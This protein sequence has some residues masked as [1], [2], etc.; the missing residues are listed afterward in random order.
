MEYSLILVL[1]V[2]IIR[3][4]GAVMLVLRKRTMKRSMIGGTPESEKPALSGLIPAGLG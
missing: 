3:A 2:D 1:P 4:V